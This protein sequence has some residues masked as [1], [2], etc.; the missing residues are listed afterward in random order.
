VYLPQL[1]QIEAAIARG[2]GEEQAAR[3]SVL[4]AID[5]AKQQEAPW[6]ELLARL[7]LCQ[8]IGATAEDRDAMAKL[9]ERL[10]E[11]GDTPLVN[12]ARALLDATTTGPMV[13]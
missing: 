8:S 6:L 2:R 3:N 1:L 10:D 5:E 11:A 7:D 12:R 4:R 9:V 13:T